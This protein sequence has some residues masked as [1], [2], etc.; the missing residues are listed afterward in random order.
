MSLRVVPL[1]LQILARYVAFSP[2]SVWTEEVAPFC[3]I[4]IIM[5]GAMI[6]VRDDTHFDVD[7]LPTPRT[8]AGHGWARLVVHI[9]MAVFAAAFI[10]YSKQFRSEERRVGKECVSTCRFWWLPYH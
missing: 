10:W 9:A 5:I 8:T 3:F 6:A 2:G 1:V 7:L 4:W